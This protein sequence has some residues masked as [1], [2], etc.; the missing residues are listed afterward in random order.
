MGS[1]ELVNVV[2]DYTYALDTL[3][4]YDYQQLTIE[5]TTIEESFCA[6]YESAMETIKSQRRKR[7]NFESYC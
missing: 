7:Y 1:R 4:R 2:T 6:T 3:D 5:H